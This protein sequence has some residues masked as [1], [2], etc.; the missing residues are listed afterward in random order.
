MYVASLHRLIH[1]SG[2]RRDITADDDKNTIKLK[3]AR[4]VLFLFFLRGALINFGTKSLVWVFKTSIALPARRC[5][6]YMGWQ[7]TENLST[8]ERLD[9]HCR[10][11][12]KGGYA[13]N[14]VC[15]QALSFEVGRV[16]AFGSKWM[17]QC[18]ARF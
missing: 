6:A 4:K 14:V 5:A 2:T 13:Y 15:V 8:R 18:C 16:Y 12:R 17:A 10:G 1:L 9:M 11:R 3:I 7:P